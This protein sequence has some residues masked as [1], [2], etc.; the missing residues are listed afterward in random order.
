[1]LSMEKGHQRRIG[2]RLPAPL[3]E[4]RRA[5]L[6]LD[7]LIALAVVIACGCEP[8][9]KQTVRRALERGSTLQEVEQTLRVV[10]TMQALPCL[11]QAVGPH[12]LACMEQPLAAAFRTFHEA[13]AVGRR[14]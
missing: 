14:G 10:G 12:V 9:A 2:D 5:E 7:N 3:A 13:S 6:S 1:M 11:A 8:C 4:A